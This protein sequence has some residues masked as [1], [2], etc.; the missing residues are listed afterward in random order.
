VHKKLPEYNVSVAV[1]T[2]GRRIHVDHHMLLGPLPAPPAS[3]SR[4][5]RAGLLLLL[6]ATLTRGVAVPVIRI[7]VAVIK[8]VVVLL[9]QLVLDVEQGQIGPLPVKN[10][11]CFTIRYTL[12]VPRLA[13][14]T[15][16]YNTNGPKWQ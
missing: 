1:S 3:N 8:G 13:T 11:C 6:L 2:L 5:G 14:N 16:R 9:L 10:Q 15:A 4:G 7:S 12:H